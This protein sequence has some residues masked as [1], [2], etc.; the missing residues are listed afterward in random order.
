MCP[1]PRSVDG[2]HVSP[3]EEEKPAQ[4]ARREPRVRTRATIATSSTPKHNVKHAL[5]QSWDAERNAAQAIAMVTTAA[6]SVRSE[7]RK[8]FMIVPYSTPALSGWLTRIPRACPV[9]P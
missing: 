6:M 1:E 8:R 9:D 4:N 3:P 5:A 7:K 2:E